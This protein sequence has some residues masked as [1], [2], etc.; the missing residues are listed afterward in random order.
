MAN[1]G[2]L[3]K[4]QFG[5]VHLQKE[6]TFI[7]SEFSTDEFN[8]RSMARLCQCDIE[9]IT[10]CIGLGGRDMLTVKAQGSLWS[11]EGSVQNLFI[12]RRLASDFIPRTR[13]ATVSLTVCV[14]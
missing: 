13:R 6:L 14:S 12:H 9:F 4:L 1:L 5:F 2:G 11:R 8:F 7:G 3:I 10:S